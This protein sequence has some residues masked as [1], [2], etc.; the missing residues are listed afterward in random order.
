MPANATGL[1]ALHPDRGVGDRDR[2]GAST[3]AG[4][5]MMARTS[6]SPPTTVPPTTGAPTISGQEPAGSRAPL[7][8]PASGHADNDSVVPIG[9]VVAVGGLLAAGVVLTLA[10]LRRR[11]QR[12]R[13]PGRRIRLPVDEA[14]RVEEQLRAAAEPEWRRLPD[15]GSARHGRPH[16]P[17]RPAAADDPGGPPRPDSPGGPAPEPHRGRSATVHPR[18]RRPAVDPSLP[19]P[20]APPGEVRR[21]RRRSPARAGDPGSQRRRPRSWSTSRRQA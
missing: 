10:R 1:P 8:A 3:P 20:R 6:P 5:D 17:A 9:T 7:G 2:A 11:Q 18:S 14:A 21:G 19:P 4:G 13:V 12:Y 15:A 16:P